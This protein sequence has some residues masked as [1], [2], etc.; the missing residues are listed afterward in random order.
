MRARRDRRPA[1]ATVILSGARAAGAVEGAALAARKMFLTFGLRLLRLRDPAG[2]FAQDDNPGLMN[3][4]Q[5][6]GNRNVMI[7]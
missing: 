5:G 2:R 1:G 7:P 3:R 6:T 4:E